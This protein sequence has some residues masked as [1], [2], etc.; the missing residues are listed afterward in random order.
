MASIATD[1]VM[2]RFATG[3]F[4][5]MR[6]TLPFAVPWLRISGI[7]YTYKKRMVYFLL[8]DYLEE[9]TVVT[10]PLCNKLSPLATEVKKRLFAL[11]WTDAKMVRQRLSNQEL[12]LLSDLGIPI[13]L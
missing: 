6:Q 2:V 13:I 9:Y 10:A 1:F 5:F 4:S 7:E 12:T 11:S 8:P 3:P